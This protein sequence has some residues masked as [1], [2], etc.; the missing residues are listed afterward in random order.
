[1]AASFEDGANARFAT[2]ANNTRSVTGSRRVVPN[3]PRR[4]LANPSRSH[5]PSNTYAPPSGRDSVNSNPGRPRHPAASLRAEQRV[6]DP[7]R[8]SIP[9]R[10]TWSARPKLYTTFI[11]DD[12]A[13]G[14]HSL[15]TSCR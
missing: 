14:S 15:W 7:I 11:L 2:R 6:S 9:A 12:F 5:R 1:M 3:R 8:R 10:S 4:V 13:V